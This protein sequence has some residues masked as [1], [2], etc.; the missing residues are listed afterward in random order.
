METSSDYAEGL[1]DAMINT[2]AREFVKDTGQK[3]IEDAR[4]EVRML[5]ACGL[6]RFTN[7]TFEIEVK[8][9]WEGFGPH[10]H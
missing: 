2:V 9:D 7:L 1:L 8:Q 10:M 6:I 4:D 5:I 3:T